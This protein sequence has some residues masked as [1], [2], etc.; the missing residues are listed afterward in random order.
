LG[1]IPASTTEPSARHHEV[2]RLIA[3]TELLGE[4]EGSGFTTPQ[5]L[6]RRHD[7]QVIR[8]SR[9]LYLITAQMD[10]VRDLEMIAG[11]VSEQMDR[12]VSVGNVAHLVASFTRTKA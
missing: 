8:I 4:Y 5:Y 12:T 7:G 6:L 1:L 11:R 2:P 3:G 10:G 9:L